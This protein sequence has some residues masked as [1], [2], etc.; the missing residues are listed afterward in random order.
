MLQQQTDSLNHA[1]KH[2]AVKKGSVAWEKNA[3][4]THTTQHEHGVRECEWA[5]YSVKLRLMTIKA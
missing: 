4:W 3:L 1:M 2:A 5:K